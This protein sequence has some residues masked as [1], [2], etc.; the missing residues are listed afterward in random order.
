MS[1]PLDLQIGDNTKQHL[2]DVVRNIEHL[3][4]EKQAIADNIKDAYD[5]LKSQGFD[6][7]TIKTVVKRRKLEKEKLEEQDYLLETYE[8]A[9]NTVEDLLK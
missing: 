8:D 5:N 9:I 2:R 7:K 1:D 3:E 4:C 6:T